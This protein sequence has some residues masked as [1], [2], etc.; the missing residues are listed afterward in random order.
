MLWR[1]RVWALAPI[2]VLVTATGCVV[3]GNPVPQRVDP[4]GLPVGAYSVESLEAPAGDESHGRIVESARMAEAMVDPFEIDPGLKYPAN[5]YGLMLLPTPAKARMLLA[6]PVRGVLEREGMVTGCASN[7]TDRDFG[8]KRP[9]AGAAQVLTIIALRFPDAA[10]ATRAARDIDAVDGAV[11][12]ENTALSISEYPQAHA[13]WR[14]GVPTMAATLADGVFVLTL[15][16]GHTTAD[17]A[18]MTTLARKTFDAQL[19]RLREFVPTPAD[20]V[21][22]LSL[23]REG[24]IRRMVPP[25][26]GRWL[27]PAVVSNTDARNAGWDARIV[28][29][30]VVY[31]PRAARLWG[32]RSPVFDGVEFIA[33]NVLNTLYRYPNAT[34][35]RTA[36]SN[37]SRKDAAGSGARVV[38]APNGIPDIHCAEDRERTGDTPKFTCRVV[39]GRYYA[40]VVSRTE[41]TVLAKAA[42]QYGLL[43]NGA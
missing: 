13:H 12:T 21:A 28:T 16:I 40:I 37:A 31:G 17:S 29:V 22:A 6:E 14:P 3:Q 39:Y 30:G 25:A 2:A 15:L 42:A 26:P 9:E 8:S 11:S 41:S 35:A 23:D 4:A 38:A 34:L 20:Q 24:M 1:A 33:M 18:A 10:A 32:N 36:F 7:G 19:P 43:I 5:T 27:Y